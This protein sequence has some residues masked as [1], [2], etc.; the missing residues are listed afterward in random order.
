[1]KKTTTIWAARSLRTAAGRHMA[2][3]ALGAVVAGSTLLPNKAFA[4]FDTSSDGLLLYWRC[5]EKG[6]RP[7]VQDS[8]G[9]GRHGVASNNVSGCVLSNV[10]A[11]AGFTT[12]DSFLSQESVGSA[13]GNWSSKSWTVVVWARNPD[14]SSTSPHTIARGVQTKGFGKGADNSWQVWLDAEGRMRAGIRYATGLHFATNSVEG[15]PA[16]EFAPDTWYQVAMSYERTQAGSAY[17]H[18]IK[19]R[20]TAAGAASVGE[21]VLDFSP[22]SA[23]V[24]YGS[25]ALCV[26]GGPGGYY[27][28]HP[29]GFFGGN[30]RDVSVWN[31]VLTD[32]ELL[33]DVQSFKDEWHD[34]DDFALLHWKMNETGTLPAAMDSTP[35]GLDG[36]S[37][38]N[39]AGRARTTT[40]NCY[41]GFTSSASYVGAVLPITFSGTRKFDVLMWVRNP[42]LREEGHMIL[43]R[44]SRDNY[45]RNSD[46]G[47]Q[48]W[49]NHDG[50]V[51]VRTRDWGGREEA[52]T[53]EPLEWKSGQW[54]QVLVRRDYLSNVSDR[55]RVYVTPA[56]QD[57]AFGDPVVTM[58][59]TRAI[60]S[61]SQFSVG[62]G[63]VGWGS[64]QPGGFW[65]GE[66]GDVSFVANAHYETAFLNSLLPLWEFHT[67]LMLVFH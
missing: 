56:G 2:A 36:T 64:T 40:T 26:G 51:S 63:E 60:G 23:Y 11:F 43:A 61:G 34:I 31:R 49:V 29:A 42:D 46:I 16:V 59:S 30:I 66:I 8:S 50:S 55:F 52:A 9:N 48:V 14:M 54:H 24:M 10:K 4:E 18:N 62:G 1:M 13:V 67:G 47:W 45:G 25:T 41:A 57:T 21:P 53:S 33:A 58:S 38:G 44:G 15:L 28:S 7:D 17:T 19:V 32:E 22:E 39:V 20:V 27:K 6:Q 37:F 65:G 12:S 5:D 35:N 3:V